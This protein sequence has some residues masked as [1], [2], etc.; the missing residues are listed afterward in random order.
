LHPD[1]TIARFTFSMRHVS[2][3]LLLWPIGCSRTSDDD[4]V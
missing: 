3:E 4:S 1:Y 2:N